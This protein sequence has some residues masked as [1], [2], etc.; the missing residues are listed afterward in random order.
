MQLHPR[1]TPPT[2]IP[3][4]EFRAINFSVTT[5]YISI[6]SV[7]L[8]PECSMCIVLTKERDNF[9]H[10]SATIISARCNTRLRLNFNGSEI[11]PL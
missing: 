5:S 1:Y 8:A 3:Y 4:R 11:N 10:I 9:F 7:I 6:T 2:K